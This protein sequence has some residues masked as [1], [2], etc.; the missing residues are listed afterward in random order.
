MKIDFSLRSIAPDGFSS[1]FHL[2]V[3]GNIISEELLS[4][5]SYSYDIDLL[6]NQ[7]NSISLSIFDCYE[8][9]DP[10]TNDLIESSSFHIDQLSI[11]G[12]NSWPVSLGTNKSLTGIKFDP[13][14]IIW[15]QTFLSKTL[16]I[17]DNQDGFKGQGSFNIEFLTDQD[18]NI[19]DHYYSYRDKLTDHHYLHYQDIHRTC[20]DEK[21]LNIGSL[22]LVPE[23][24]YEL[25]KNNS[26]YCQ[27][28]GGHLVDIKDTTAQQ[29]AA[30][31][32]SAMK[33]PYKWI[34]A[35]Y[36]KDY[37]PENCSRELLGL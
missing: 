25:Y 7:W 30:Q 33:W 11:N 8:L 20:F 19:V 37:L 27:K 18:L 24:G 15:K 29:H 23:S 35:S 36:Y 34:H 14:Y 17:P 32:I 3:N 22:R 1:Y 9:F 28:W 16:Y 10:D 6:P 31:W 13:V 26:T 21:L 4:T 2:L 12:H 5:Q